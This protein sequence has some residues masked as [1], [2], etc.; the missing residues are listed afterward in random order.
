MALVLAYFCTISVSLAAEP[1]RAARRVH[2]WWKAPPA[3]A[4]YREVVVEHPPVYISPAPAAAT[5]PAAP[6]NITIINNYY[7]TP[8]TPMSAANGLFGRN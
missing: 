7:N 3:Q 4:V 6:Q 1:P 5:A 8:A 2:L